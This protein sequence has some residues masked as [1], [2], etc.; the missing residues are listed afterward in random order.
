M[1][2]ISITEFKKK[3][4]KYI[5]MIEKGTIDE[6]L[7]TRYKKIIFKVTPY[8]K[9]TKPRIG[10]GVG[11]LPDLPYVLDSKEYGIEELFSD[12]NN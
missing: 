8:H 10:G 7:I 5:E 6:I 11:I 3:F 1:K 9:T 12:S 4:E 2:I